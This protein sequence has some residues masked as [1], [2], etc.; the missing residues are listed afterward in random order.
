MTSRAASALVVA[1][2]LFNLAFAVFHL[3]FWR[4]FD[5]R[6]EL[7]RLGAANRG[8]MQVLNLCLTYVFVVSAVLLLFFPPQA[9]ATEMGAF[10]LLAMAGFWLLRAV[11]QPMFFQLR[12]PLSQGLFVVFVIGTLLHGAAWWLMLDRN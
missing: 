4:L 5:W 1:A 2:G 7:A 3:L 11:L 12:H 9:F 8:I 6:I 10:L